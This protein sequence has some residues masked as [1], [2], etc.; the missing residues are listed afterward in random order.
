[1]RLLVTGREGQVVRSL[2]KLGE[3][4][5]DLQ[6]SAVGRPEL[7]LAK[8][9]DLVGIFEPLAPDVIVNAAAY[10]AVDQAESE[11]DLASGSMLVVQALWREPPVNSVSRSFKFPPTTSSRE[12]ERV[13]ISSRT[14]FAR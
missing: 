2:L 10:T 8:D 6:V 12:T 11:T 5:S 3:R 7:D 13:P 1:M 14:R 4:Q 9:S